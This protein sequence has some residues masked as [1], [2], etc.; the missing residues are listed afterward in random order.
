M[1][2]TDK[3]IE[4]LL[5]AFLLVV[6]WFFAEQELVLRHDLSGIRIQL[7]NEQQCRVGSACANKLADESAR[8]EALV[9]RAQTAASTAAAAQKAA[10]DQAALDATNG[11]AQTTA[12]AQ[13]EA[14]AWKKKYQALLSTPSCDAWA[15]QAVECAV[16]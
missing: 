9:G 2:L 10:M 7:V 13:A 5:G 12:Q 1:G 11:L 6:L 4:I 15:K 8:G 3:A 16:H 14:A